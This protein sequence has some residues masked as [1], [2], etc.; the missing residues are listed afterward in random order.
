MCLA[1]PMRV[2]RVEGGSCIAEYKGVERR[3]SALLID[4]LKEGD[5]I[6]IHAGFAIAKVEKEEA[7]DT[8]AIIEEC[9]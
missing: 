5:Y 7:E 4:D 9:L 1:I 6:L 3:V 8:I 2:K